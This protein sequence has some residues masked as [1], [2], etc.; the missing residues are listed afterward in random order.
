MLIQTVTMYVRDGGATQI[1]H[2][3][4]KVLQS[5]AFLIIFSSKDISNVDQVFVFQH[6]L[7]SS[8]PLLNAS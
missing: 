8:Q 3:L 6:N 4:S 1:I 2:A 5:T 7:D